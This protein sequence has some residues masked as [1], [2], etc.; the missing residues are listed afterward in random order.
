M[1]PERGAATY[2]ST[3][4]LRDTVMLFILGRLT[5]VVSPGK[6]RKSTFSSENMLRA[7]QDL[8]Q[9][10]TRS[11]RKVPRINPPTL[12]HAFTEFVSPGPSIRPKA[13]AVSGPLLLVLTK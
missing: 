4:I 2:S 10:V 3:K 7:I 5:L 9:A 8:G 1:F 6:L 12:I 11:A 13:R